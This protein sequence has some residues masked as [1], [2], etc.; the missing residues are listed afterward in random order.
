MKKCITC[1]KQKPIK[2][3]YKHVGHSDGMSSFCKPCSN[4]KTRDSYR[5]RRSTKEGHAKQIFDKRKRIAKYENIP[6]DITLEYML[7]LMVD[8]CPVLGIP[9]S[10]CKNSGKPTGDSPSIDKIIPEKGYVEGNVAWVSY[11][12]NSIKSDANLSE[13][14]AVVK[15]LQKHNKK[16]VEK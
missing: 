12:A 1:S 4:K 2:D 9:L 16:V 5:A 10:W 6:F 8:T 3:F 15:Y 7:S 14:E 13:I 11:R